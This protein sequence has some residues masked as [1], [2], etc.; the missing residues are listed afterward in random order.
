MEQEI[1]CPRCN[2]IMRVGGIK[3]SN[4]LIRLAQPQLQPVFMALTF[5]F[6]K[7]T[8]YTEKEYSMRIDT[9][10]IKTQT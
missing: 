9:V 2:D 4:Y 3:D 6:L 5:S 8:V 7:V 10:T 1:E